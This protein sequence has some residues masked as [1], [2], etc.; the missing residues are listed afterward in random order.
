[1][2]S[3]AHHLC[4]RGRYV[5]CNGIAQGVDHRTACRTCL[6]RSQEELKEFPSQMKRSLSLVCMLAST[7]GASA[8]AQAPAPS[9]T[10]AEPPS[11]P[12]APAAPAGPAKI[13]VI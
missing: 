2:V 7:L 9:Q 10:A 4:P 5:A 1:R 12:G 13:A 6:D 11:A 8:L 3:C